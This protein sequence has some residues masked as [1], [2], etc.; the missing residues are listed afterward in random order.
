MIKIEFKEVQELFQGG[1]RNE[2]KFALCKC[3]S[4]HPSLLCMG[5]QKSD[6]FCNFFNIGSITPYVPTQD[7]YLDRSF[8]LQQLGISKEQDEEM[9]LKYKNL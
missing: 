4:K 2:Y 6:Q 8:I 3:L 1:V 9:Q 5:M 7:S